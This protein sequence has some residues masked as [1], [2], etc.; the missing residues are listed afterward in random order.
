MTRRQMTPTATDAD[1]ARFVLSLSGI[2]ARVRRL[3][4]SLRICLEGEVTDAIRAKAT[5]ALAD[6]DLF[7]VLG[8]QLSWEQGYQAFAY[9]VR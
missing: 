9:K 1:A 2:K 8:G 7:G 4:F 5:A 3:R 6:A